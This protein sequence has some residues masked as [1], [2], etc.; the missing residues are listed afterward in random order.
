MSSASPTRSRERVNPVQS[1]VNNVTRTWAPPAGVIYNGDY[2]PYNDCDLFN[3]N[4]NTKRPGQ[5]AVR[6]RSTTRRSDR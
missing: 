6:C 2:N 5:I 4:A 3:P 1:S